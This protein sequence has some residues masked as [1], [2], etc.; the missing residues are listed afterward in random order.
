MLWKQK[1]CEC[2]FDCNEDLVKIENLAYSDSIYYNGPVEGV[3][4]RIFDENNIYVKE[5][6]KIVRHN[7]IQE[8]DNHWTRNKTIINKLTN[9]Y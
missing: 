8:G 7:F 5:R 2:K 1:I 9:N 4:L 6:A 3:Y